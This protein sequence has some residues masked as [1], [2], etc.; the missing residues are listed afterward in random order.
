MAV[1]RGYGLRVMPAI[2][3]ERRAAH[4]RNHDVPPYEL[5]ERSV[6]DKRDLGVGDQGKQPVKCS[7]VVEIRRPP[8]KPAI[9]FPY[10]AENFC[11]RILSIASGSALLQVGATRCL[12]IKDDIHGPRHRNAS[13]QAS[14]RVFP[15]VRRRRCDASV[16]PHKYEGRDARLREQG[17]YWCCIYH[18]HHQAISRE[19]KPSPRPNP[20]ALSTS[21]AEKELCRLP[22]RDERRL[23]QTRP[24]LLCRCCHAWLVR[25][26]FE[27]SNVHE[28]LYGGS[29][30]HASCSSHG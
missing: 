12:E 29:W 25:Q 22:L 30:H 11:R 4:L 18:H 27:V 23:A 21:L 9:G 3:R 28:G 15:S 8:I 16:A 6:A 7:R 14:H 17:W 2:D 1:P 10:Q 5:L 19:P 24:A 13:L 26:H 20:L